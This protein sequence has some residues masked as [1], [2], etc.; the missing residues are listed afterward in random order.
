MNVFFIISQANEM[1]LFNDT[2]KGQV[3]VRYR[4]FISE[5]QLR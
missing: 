2:H 4:S 5:V 3:H 1:N